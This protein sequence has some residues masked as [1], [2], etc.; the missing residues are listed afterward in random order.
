MFNHNVCL[1]ECT[2]KPCAFGGV[3]IAGEEKQ[4][5]QLGF[6]YEIA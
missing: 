3:G 1:S 2:G 4:L 5:K 6:S